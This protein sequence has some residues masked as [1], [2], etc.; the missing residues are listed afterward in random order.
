MDE[1]IA[2]SV[3][4]TRNLGN[5]NSIKLAADMTTAVKPDESVQEAFARAWTTCE[6]EVENKIEEALAQAE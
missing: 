1:T 4:I 2:V 6:T 3:S 5:F